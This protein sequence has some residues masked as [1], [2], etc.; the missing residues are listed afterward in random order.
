[1]RI[2]FL[3]KFL[4]HT[5]WKSSEWCH[6][7]WKRKSSLSR[8]NPNGLLIFVYIFRFKIKSKLFSTFLFRMKTIHFKK[9]REK[10]FAQFPS[11]WWRLTTLSGIF[12]K[13][14]KALSSRNEAFLMSREE[15]EKGKISWVLFLVETCHNWKG[16][17]IMFILTKSLA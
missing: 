9:K 16:R 15:E 7:A 1:M 13:Q 4:F 17:C 11:L 14:S 2:S 10:N 3:R 8:N 5:I 12:Q 6:R